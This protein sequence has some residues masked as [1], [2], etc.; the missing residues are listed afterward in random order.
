MCKPR[1]MELGVWMDP[2]LWVVALPT[3]VDYS[4]HPS[5]SWSLEGS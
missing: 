1:L 3:Y 5:P 2:S 4:T